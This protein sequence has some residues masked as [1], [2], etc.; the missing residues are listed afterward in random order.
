MGDIKN[1]TKTFDSHWNSMGIWK[2]RNILAFCSKY[3]A[4]TLFQNLRKGSLLWQECGI[5]HNWHPLLSMIRYVNHPSRGII[6][7]AT[8]KL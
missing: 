3:N 5:L 1:D 7:L 6:I 8:W 4:L 2:V